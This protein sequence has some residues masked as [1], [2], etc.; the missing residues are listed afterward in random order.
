[1]LFK[2]KLSF[3]SHKNQSLLCV[4]LDPDPAYMP[5]SDV[6][7]FCKQIIDCTGDLVAAYKPNLAFFEALGIEGLI[8][9]KN[10]INYLK[11]YYPDIVIIGDAK[12]GDIGPSSKKYAESMFKYWDFDATTV[13][14]FA[15]HDSMKPFL[16][17]ENRGIFIWCKSSNPDGGDFQD[18]SIAGEENQL[19]FKE[20]ANKA[21]TWNK[22][23]NIGLIVGATYPE[24]LNEVRKI[25]PTMPVLLPGI[26]SQK[27]N[28]E[29]CLKYG[30]NGSPESLLITSSRSIIYASDSK[31]K[32]ADESGKVCDRIR[33]SINNLIY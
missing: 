13:N 14:A 31:S 33:K 12:R 9:L 3:A 15:G 8:T 2:D 11:I 20:I 10:I 25:A 17:Y 4:G 1:M 21:N 27:G 18:L 28:L 5:I 23:N 24:Q 32:F 30:Y 16:E 7:E 6:Y 29:A 19:L 22:H 26:G